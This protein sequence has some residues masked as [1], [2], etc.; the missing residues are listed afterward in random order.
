MIR[1][2]VLAVV[3][4]SA[5]GCAAERYASVDCDCPR[6]AAAQ[7]EIVLHAPTGQWVASV[8]TGYSETHELYSIVLP[9]RPMS[10]RYTYSEIQLSEV[11]DFPHRP[12]VLTGGYV[13]LDVE[14]REVVVALETKQGQFLRNGTYPIQYA[15]GAF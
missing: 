10:R 5:A 13:A 1:A 4:A 9:S 12:V 11:W 7:W 15:N 6:G 14:K 3:L 2:M 8:H